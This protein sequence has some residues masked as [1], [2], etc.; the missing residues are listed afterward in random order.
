MTDHYACSEC[1]FVYP[2]GKGVNETFERKDAESHYFNGRPMGGSY[3][4]EGF[5]GILVFRVCPK[6]K[7]QEK[8]RAIPDPRG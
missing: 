2:Y 6:C 4:I 1:R 5:H 8:M 7:N 3:M